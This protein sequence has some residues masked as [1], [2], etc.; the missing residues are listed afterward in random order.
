[1]NK[2]MLLR[3]NP[4]CPAIVTGV[5]SILVTLSCG[6]AQ[7]S[8]PSASS[9][10]REDVVSL[11]ALQVTGT[12]LRSLEEVE[13]RRET[14]NIADSLTMD[15]LGNLADE[16]L[17]DALIRLPGISAMQTLYGEQEASYVS[18]RG[19][20]AD[21]SYTSFDGITMFSTANNGDGLRRVD[22][23]LIPTQISRTTR[24]YKSFTADLD[25]GAIGGVTNIEPYS[26]LKDRR[27]ANIR[28]Q[29]TGE[30]GQGKYISDFY[31]RTGNYKNRPI[32]GALSGLYVNR[33]GRDGRF[34][35]VL[36]GVY[37]QRD[38]SYTK[39][40]PNGRVYYTPTSTTAASNLSNW[41]G[42]HPFP[43]IYR[44][45]DY[46]KYSEMYGGSAKFEYRIS[47]V[48]SV[49]LLGFDYK[50]FEDQD[51][52][53]FYLE[54]FTALTRPSPD[55]GRFK[56][57]RVRSIY[58]YDR[59]AQET[60]GL[61]FKVEGR[62]S[63]DSTLELRAGAYQN[64]FYNKDETVTFL[65]SPPSSFVTFD[66]SGSLFPKTT[67]ENADALA[68][69]SS[70]RLSSA[71]I[72]IVDSK[73][74]SKQ[75]RI[76]YKKNYSNNS[77]GFGYAAGA[78]WRETE[79]SRDGTTTNFVNNS[80]PL[81]GMGF[82]PDFR[83]VNYPYPVVWVNYTQFAQTV[84]PNLAVNQNSTRNASWESDYFYKEQLFAAYV[85]ARYSW[86]STKLIA[87]ARYDKVDYDAR[88]P[89]AGASGAFDG[90]FTPS[91]GTWENL[92]PSA[93]VTHYFTPG[94]RARAAVSKS[95]G[96]P[97]FDDIAQ[98]VIR[99][100]ENLTI[101]RGNPNLKPRRSTN[102]D[103]ALEY[104][105][106]KDGM[107]SLTGFAKDIK[108]DIYTQA[109]D[110]EID[111]VVYRATQPYNSS[112]SKIRG[113]EV[114]LMHNAI[115][116]LPGVFE[117]RVGVALNYTKLWAEMNYLSGTTYVRLKSLQYQP[118]Y[119]AN[120]TIFYTFPR[121][122]G[123]IRIS[124]NWKGKSPI[125]LGLYPW[126]TYWLRES[127]RLDV[128]IRY[129]LTQNFIVKLQA[130]NLTNQGVKQ[131]YLAPFEMNRYEMDQD[132]TYALDFTYKF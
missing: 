10:G 95:L 38:Y 48:W 66:Y 28:L 30:T 18:V 76:D 119:M 19:I 14:L 84:L 37:R 94:L 40:N 39:T 59:F 132:R 77:P 124:Y 92:L 29:L 32:G 98:A 78:D 65:Y 64:E 80:A 61:I 104:F 46:T 67:V 55:V 90:T 25:A 110:E 79:V 9:H 45:M 83:S 35:V 72:N 88:S 109:V 13:N 81:T 91:G 89:L 107:A 63:T 114:A 126:T 7:S 53:Q 24:V 62:L 130:R 111:G 116:G 57:G 127:E 131:G 21:L 41:D 17:A 74:D 68:S 44:P 99:N 113:V 34:G 5:F 33:F 43:T 101:T 58:S 15:E 22:L 50:K 73:V 118:D 71:P 128:G 87:G 47:D 56:I 26:A 70:F 93:I 86:E 106:S 1:M 2:R 97:Q 75:V 105:F 36:S 4:S 11:D 60:R 82:V 129:S 8:A 103:L 120:A 31:T 115:P 27:T 6:F 20:P 96:R 121:K 12:A 108:D 23:N 42:L 85:S 117:K 123:E 69:V 16:N 122:K 49:S 112:Q 125:S 54:T 102:Y 3:S 51:L 52:D 100:D